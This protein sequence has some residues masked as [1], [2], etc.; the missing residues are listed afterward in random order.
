MA[1]RISMFLAGRSAHRWPMPSVTGAGMWPGCWPPGARASAVWRWRPGWAPGP[2]GMGCGRATRRGPAARSTRLSGRPAT[3]ASAGWPSISWL[4]EPTSTPAPTTHTPRLG[5]KPQ[6]PPTPGA[7]FSLTGSRSAAPPKPDAGRLP[8]YVGGQVRQGRMEP[9]GV[10]LRGDAVWDVFGDDAD[11]R[12]RIG[13]GDPPGHDHGA[14]VSGII[15]DEVHRL[16]DP[17]AGDDIDEASLDDVGICGR[18]ARCARR[19]GIGKHHP[20]RPAR[21]GIESLKPA[22]HPG[23]RQP[24]QERP[25]IDKSGPDALGWRGD[26]PRRPVRT[27]HPAT[28][29]PSDLAGSGTRPGTRRISVSCPLPRELSITRRSSPQAGWFAWLKI[30]K[31]H[32]SQDVHCHRLPV[33]GRSSVRTPYRRYMSGHGSSHLLRAGDLSRS[34]H[35]LDMQPGRAGREAASQPVGGGM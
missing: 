26:H 20:V 7:R 10:V 35:A 5:S 2:P 17:L 31:T 8:L 6:A 34:W 11:A 33:T 30:A 28:L 23:R 9:R 14:G 19:V 15:G 13:G 29:A 16:H 24:G 4:R 3:A 1:A 22:S 27:R 21:P 25:G 12:P 32:T 18:L